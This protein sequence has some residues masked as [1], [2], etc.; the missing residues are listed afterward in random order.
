M[1]SDYTGLVEQAYQDL[2]GR[3]SDTGGLAS[4]TGNLESGAITPDQLNDYMIG[5]AG[6]NDLD[7]YNSHMGYVAP[8]PPP[9]SYT[10]LVEQAY[11]DLFDRAP[12]AEG[13][14]YWTNSMDTGVV[15]PDRL[16]DYLLG[17]ATQADLD[18]YNSHMGYVAPPPPAP[19]PAPAPSPPA[20][21]A[22]DYPLDLYQSSS[23][24]SEHSSYSGLPTKYQE[25]LLQ[26][27]MP[28]LTQSIEGMS[29]NIDQYNEEA[30]KAY[31]SD[32]KNMATKAMPSILNDVFGRNMQESSIAG[33]VTSKV[34]SDIVANLQPQAHQTAMQSAKLKADMPG[35]L[36]NIAGLGK[37]NVSSSASTGEGSDP[38]QPY[39]TALDF[40]Q[41]MMY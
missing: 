31:E 7:Y 1:S 18:Y 38:G 14:D 3:A 21:P 39:R 10:G 11:Q 36:S 12:K 29:G 22:F 13:L 9:S 27:I 20:P 34:L 41:T 15:A 6:G 23:N 24:E 40:L 16:N 4:W 25:S 2:F 33:D 8:P 5:G 35:L 19:P 28:Q 32:F 17:G 26:A 30:M 37:Y